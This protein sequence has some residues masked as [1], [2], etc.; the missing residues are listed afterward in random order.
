ML[1]HQRTN[2]TS[3]EYHHDDTIKRN[4][5]DQIFPWRHLQTHAN[6]HH[7]DSACSMSGG[8]TEH[9]VAISLGQTEQ[10]T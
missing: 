8:Q 5:I 4:I 2:H 6:H 1:C 3:E 7:S 10:Q 9:H